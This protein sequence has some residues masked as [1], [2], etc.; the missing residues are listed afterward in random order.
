MLE[1]PIKLN[2]VGDW[3]DARKKA[4]SGGATDTQGS[5]LTINPRGE[6]SFTSRMRRRGIGSKLPSIN[7]S[8]KGIHRYPSSTI[9]QLTSDAGRE[10]IIRK[11]KNVPEGFVANFVIDPRTSDSRLRLTDKG[12]VDEKWLRDKGFTEQELPVYPD[13]IN[14]VFMRNDGGDTIDMTAWTIAH[15]FGHMLGYGDQGSDGSY[16]QQMRAELNKLNSEFNRHVIHVLKSC[17]GVEDANDSSVEYLY[18]V[19]SIMSM[20]SARDMRI[21]NSS[22]VAPELLSQYI[23]KRTL[24]FRDLPPY[25]ISHNPQK[26]YQEEDPEHFINKKNKC[27][28]SHYLN[29]FAKKELNPWL[30]RI[31]DD[32]IGKV[33]VM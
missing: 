9:L 30:Q 16:Q 25:V 3:G 4:K 27:S 29:D 21:A 18:L 6:D 26:Y 1:M 33:F 10:K 11:F 14:L 31:L 32:A 17:Y 24:F 5:R 7:K 2:L 13:K 20:K 28:A 12:L 15:R 8:V 19:N 22:D 23:F